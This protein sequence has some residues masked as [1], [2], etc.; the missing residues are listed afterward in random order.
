[1]ERKWNI[2]RNNQKHFQLKEEAIELHKL[3]G[4]P[5]GK[6]AATDIQKFQDVLGPQN[7]RLVV[8]GLREPNGIIYEG[9]T[10]NQN[11]YLFFHNDHFDLIGKIT[12]FVNRDYFCHKCLKGYNNKNDHPCCSK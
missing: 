10:G 8:Y 5:A 11:L 7:W 3:A 6:V 4:V 2:Y 1:M 12:G 9:K